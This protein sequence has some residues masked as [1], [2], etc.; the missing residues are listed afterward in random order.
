MF[1]KVTHIANGYHEDI[2]ARVYV[3]KGKKR[4]QQL[5]LI[6][7]GEESTETGTKETREFIEANKDYSRIGSGYHLKFYTD[8]PLSATVY[9]SIVLMSSNGKFT[10]KNHPIKVNRS[11]IVDQKGYLVMAKYSTGPFGESSIWK[12]EDGKNHKPIGSA[13]L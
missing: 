7:P 13:N 9:V 5:N 12:D 6:I 1:S 11:V 8:G 3:E 4:K 10:C 2:Y